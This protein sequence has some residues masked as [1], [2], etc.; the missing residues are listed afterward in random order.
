LDALAREV[1]EEVGLRVVS[2]SFLRR[3]EHTEDRS[4]ATSLFFAELWLLRVRLT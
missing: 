1:A 2:G 3:V 4:G